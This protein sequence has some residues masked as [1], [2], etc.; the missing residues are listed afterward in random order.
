MNTIRKTNDLG[1][2]TGL[3]NT[4]VWTLLHELVIKRLFGFLSSLLFKLITSTGLS[5][6]IAFLGL[7]GKNILVH[8]KD[9][10]CL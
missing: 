10:N 8:A 1:K 3:L 2:T 6:N 5:E 4:K 7:C 9:V